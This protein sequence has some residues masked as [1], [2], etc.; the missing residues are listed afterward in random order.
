M[1][2]TVT[3]TRITGSDMAPA[4]LQAG[5]LPDLDVFPE[6][7]EARE[8]AQ[9]LRAAWDKAAARRRDVE[10]RIEAYSEQRK[11]MMRDAYLHGESSPQ[12]KDQSEKLAAELVEASEHAQAACEAFTEHL[13]YCIGLVI[14]HRDEWQAEIEAFDG[15]VDSE[16]RALQVQVTEL[17][18]RRGHYARLAHWIERTVRGGELPVE[19][20]PYS[21]VTAPLP[22]DQKAYEARS[23]EIFERAY[24]GGLNPDRRATETE[25]RAMETRTLAPPQQPVNHAERIVIDD[26][27]E[28]DDEDLVDWLMGTGGFDGQPKPTVEQVISVAEGDARLAGRLLKA[29]QVADP[30]ATRQDLRDRLGEI[31]NGKAGT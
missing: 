24:A 10:A 23:A 16:L 3:F 2:D 12:V 18:A 4:V 22:E 29:E 1:S 15:S 31:S 25:A 26:Y 28:L 11:A 14:E 30:E 7:T 19:H 17:C 27:D 6:L 21:E 9:Q 20:F 5:W 8:K 13:N